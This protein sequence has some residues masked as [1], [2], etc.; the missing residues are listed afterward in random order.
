VASMSNVNL[1]G[2]IPFAVPGFPPVGVRLMLQSARRCLR[3]ENLG[4]CR[5]PLCTRGAKRSLSQSWLERAWATC[6]L[7]QAVNA[8]GSR[9][10]AAIDSEEPSRWNMACRVLQSCTSPIL[11]PFHSPVRR[12][13]LRRLAEDALT[14]PSITHADNTQRRRRKEAPGIIC[15][16]H[17]EK[18][19]DTLTLPRHAPRRKV[20][21]PAILLFPHV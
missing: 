14:M 1:A 9:R 7:R 8:R 21:A 11:L 13:C 20:M 18:W 16:L 4:L 10:M 19:R 3:K 15:F 6:A 17:A 2:D 5:M 12:T